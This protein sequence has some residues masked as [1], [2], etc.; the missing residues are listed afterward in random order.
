KLNFIITNPG[1][2]L[3]LSESYPLSWLA[4]M[5]TRKHKGSTNTIGS[6]IVVRANSSIQTLEDLRGKNV[7]ALDPQALG[8]YK[9]TLG[10]LLERGHAI[11]G[12]FGQLQFLGFPNEALIYQV[13]DG[14]F[15]AA[16]T[17]FCTLEDMVDSGLVE[18]SH[19]RVINGYI[20]QGCECEASTPLYPSWSFAAADL[21]SSP[22]ALEVSQALFNLSSS[23]HA[24]LSADILGWTSPVSQLK[25]IELY[26]N[27]QRVVASPYDTLQTWLL[28]NKEW[29]GALLLIFIVSTIYHLWLEYKFRQKSDF[30]LN[31]E[32]QLKDKALQLERLQSAAIL[33]EI[34]AGLAHELNQPIAAITQYSEGAMLQLER[35]GPNNPELYDVIEKINA[36]SIRAGAV[37]HRIRGLLKRRQVKTEP[38]D[39]V[40]VV[41]EALA[42]LRR[43]LDRANVQVNVRI[44]GEPFELIGDSVGLSQMWVNLVKNSLDALDACSDNRVGQLWIDIYYHQN[45][46]KVLVIDNGEGLQ[47]LAS[48]LMASFA[49]TKEAGLGLGLAICKDVASRHHGSI[50]I[51]NCQQSTHVLLP[52]QQGCVVTVVLPKG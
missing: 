4:T 41:T 38:L 33:G 20:P 14:S 32:R 26:K 11:D 43:E 37:V 42:L 46:I 8:G 30:L 50:Q 24:A 35:L 2:F 39:I 9:A 7:A 23:H 21:V 22:V 28:N 44:Y 3:Y 27:L 5:R 34:G 36:Q 19:Y 47:G 12:F 40:L 1:Q 18:R 45:E 13:R 31:T 51:E 29:G 52:W 15:D 16:I 10:L 6:A 17:P 25:T 49:S 48:E